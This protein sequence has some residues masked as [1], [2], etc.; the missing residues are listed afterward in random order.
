MNHDERQEI[1][2]HNNERLSRMVDG[3]VYNKR[4]ILSHPRKQFMSDIVDDIHRSIFYKR[5]PERNGEKS[6]VKT[7]PHV[8][9][10]VKNTMADDIKMTVGDVA[11]CLMMISEIYKVP[12]NEMLQ[13]LHRELEVSGL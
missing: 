9:Q 1:Q 5:I 7:E 6:I 3:M 13:I 11:V 2:R 12:L 4:R 10:Y 8:L